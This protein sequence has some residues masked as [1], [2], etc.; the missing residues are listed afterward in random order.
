MWLELQT[1]MGM[2][3]WDESLSLQVKLGLG[4]RGSVRYLKGLGLGSPVRHLKC[5][6][7]WNLMWDYILSWSICVTSTLP[8]LI[9][10]NTLQYRLN[11]SPL[12]ALTDFR[13]QNNHTG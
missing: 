1:R 5:H 12:V 2:E 4:L 3:I 8:I 6:F 13:T 10:F 9:P 11:K 7:I